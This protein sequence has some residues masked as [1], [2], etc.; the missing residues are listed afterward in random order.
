MS[1]T[2]RRYV[3]KRVYWALGAGVGGWLLVMLTGATTESNA[4]ASIILGFLIVLVSAIAT[5]WI[6][7]P[8]CST[9]LG[10]SVA[11]HVAVPAGRPRINFCPYCGVS[12]D[13][14]RTQHETAT[15]S[16]NPVNPI[17]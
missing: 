10:Q 9:R 5:R 17:S 8:K 11:I 16:T 4:R 12:L 3:K 1:E 2:N 6:K 15:T 14:P 7:C 13:E